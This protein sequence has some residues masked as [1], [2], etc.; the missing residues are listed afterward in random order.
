[1]SSNARH[2]LPGNSSD[3]EIDDRPRA[4]DLVEDSARFR[5]QGRRRR[6]RAFGGAARHAQEAAQLGQRPQGGVADDVHRPPG[7]VGLAGGGSV[8]AACTWT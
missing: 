7:L 8:A 5:E 1:M 3:F 4:A 6:L 2:D